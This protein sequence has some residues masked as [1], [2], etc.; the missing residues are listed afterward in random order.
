MTDFPDGTHYFAIDMPTRP[1][2][3]PL[4][5]LVVE[6]GSWTSED[7][8]A[9]GRGGWIPTM[10]ITKFLMGQSDSEWVR[11]TP[12]LAVEIVRRWDEWCAAEDAKDSAEQS[13][14]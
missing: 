5:R 9:V 11:V 1:G 14:S 7:W 10:E 2:V 6:S 4:Y 13:P 12:E 3:P 8:Y